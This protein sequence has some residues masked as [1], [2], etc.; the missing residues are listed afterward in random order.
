LK[1]KR[2]IKYIDEDLQPH[3]FRFKSLKTPKNDNATPASSSPSKSGTSFPMT[4]FTS[5]ELKDIN[6]N[7]ININ[8]NNLEKQQKNSSLQSTSFN[9]LIVN[10]FNEVSPEFD[11]FYRRLT[12]I[13]NSIHNS[14]SNSALL[15]NIYPKLNEFSFNTESQ[16]H[17]QQQQQQKQHQLNRLVSYSDTNINYHPSY[18]S[19]EEAEG[20]AGLVNSDGSLNL[21]MVLTGVHSVILKENSFKVCEL[22]LNILDNLLNIDILPSA[23]IDLQLEQTRAN[24]NLAQSSYNYLDDLEEKY[25]KNF[26]LATDLA[27]RNIKWLGCA[28]CQKSKTFLNDQLRGKIRL[29]L[30]RL[31]KRNSKRFESFF[32]SFIET[33]ELVYIMETLHALLGYCYDPQFGYSHYYPY[34]SLKQKSNFNKSSIYANNFGKDSLKNQDHEQ[35]VNIESVMVDLMLK[36]LIKRLIG[37]Q[38][39]IMNQENLYLFSDIRM[40]LSY[41]K[42]NHG[43]VFRKVLFSNM[44]EPLMKLKAKEQLKRQRLRQIDV[45]IEEVRQLK[46]LALEN[47]AANKHHVKHHHYY[48]PKSHNLLSSMRRNKNIIDNNTNNDDKIENDQYEQQQQQQQQ[49]QKVSDGNNQKASTKSNKKNVELRFSVLR[50]KGAFLFLK[51]HIIR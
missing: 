49:Q 18:E 16:N 2:R 29:M 10:N 23:D 50:T 47:E 32:K 37:I 8:T 21:N 7:N 41:I 3:R 11:D 43:G 38:N 30:S 26:H 24:L 31:Q 42:E 36:P 34:I 6:K 45:Y 12:T 51:N 9:N 27:L 40:L 46:E 39:E 25:N 1:N 35:M 14:N 19:V 5:N 4:P 44:L 17:H 15:K 22:A 33:N 13:N 48:H 20:S 28:N